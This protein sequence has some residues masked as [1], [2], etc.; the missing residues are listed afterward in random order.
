[1]I[2]NG[3]LLESAD[4]CLNFMRNL[5]WKGKKSITKLKEV[6][7]E[8]GLTVKKCEMKQLEKEYIVR[9]EGIEKWSVL[10]TP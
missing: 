5:T 8:K 4:I 6:K 2:W 10:I 3:F 7:Y 9:T 1:N